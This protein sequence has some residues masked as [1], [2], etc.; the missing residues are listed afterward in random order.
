MKTFKKKKNARTKIQFDIWCVKWL[1]NRIGQGCICNYS[2][3][4]HSLVKILLI[5]LK[6]RHSSVCLKLNFGTTKQKSKV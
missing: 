3:T 5:K 2:Y 1:K 6:N 4:L